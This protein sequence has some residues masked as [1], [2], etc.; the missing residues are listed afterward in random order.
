MEQ[1]IQA[2]TAFREDLLRA[3]EKVDRPGSFSTSG[4]LPLTMPGLEVEGVGAIRLPLGKTQAA[5]LIKRCSQAPYGK[6]TKT[7]VDTDVRRVWELDPKHITFTNPK[8]DAVVAS[9]TNQARVALGLN[10]TKLHPNFYK[11]LVYETGSF[12]LPHRDGEKLDGMVATLVIA[13]PSPHT[14]GELIVSHEGRRDEITLA[15]A[16]SGHEMSYATFYADCEHEVRPVRN[17]Y[18]LCLVYNLTLGRSRGKG[19]VLAPRTAEVVASISELLGNWPQGEKIAKLAVTLEHQYTQDG[20]NID[21]LKGIDRARADVLF[22]AAE[23]AGCTAH[24]G[25]I[26]HWQSGSAEGD[27]Y[28]YYSRGRD[29]Y[30]SWSYDDEDQEDSHEGTGHEMGEVYEE[31]ISINHW[32]DRSG[33]K[34]AYGEMELEAAEIVSDVP[35]EDWDLGREEFE[36]YTG[37]AGMTLER[38]YHR[39]AIVIW[40][41]QNNFTVLCDAGTDA[42]ISGLKSM[43]GKWKRARK[44]DQPEQRKSCLE[45]AAAIIQRWSSPKFE[46][47]SYTVKEKVDRSVFP[48]L[49]QELD[50]PDSVVRFMTE[51]MPKE[52]T[53]ELGK[54]FP[55]FCK[56]HGWPTFETGLT[57][58]LDEATPETIAR[59]TTLLETL[60]LHS[61]KNADR[62]NVCKEVAERAVNALQRLDNHSSDSDWYIERIDRA[63]MLVSLVRS[64][65]SVDATESL[66]EL[67]DHTLSQVKTYDLT[68]AHLAAI[69]ALESWL[70][71]KLGK[72]DRIVARWLDH[73]RTELERRTEHNPTPPTDFRRAAKLSCNCPECLELSGF[74]ADPNESVHRFAVRKDRRQHLHQIID[75][76]RCDLTHVTTRTSNPHTLVCTKTTASYQLA[77]KNYARDRE[78]LK[79]LRA[80]EKTIKPAAGS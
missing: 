79:R 35:R 33:H 69:F 30:R 29:R 58:I 72:A 20:L 49:L 38:W 60:C 10:D 55:S 73:C 5:A 17:G 2:P 23:Q 48:L 14:G 63:G 9:I 57:A 66:D 51:V 27:D 76:D 36:G 15:G 75:G 67:I 7:L 71:R 77:C 12:F 1:V 41:K 44:S 26:T 43:V 18:R 46:Y 74:L 50:D 21:T 11:L 24:L 4:D 32:S 54:S 31:S 28:G 68:D 62:M 3:I 37:N 42:A 22:D 65:R 25:L 59:N 52:G 19:G 64:L 78:N 61:D 56:R 45:F 13:L 80:V 70:H 47:H 16:A 34:I 39:A 8:W 40:P 6:G 53:I